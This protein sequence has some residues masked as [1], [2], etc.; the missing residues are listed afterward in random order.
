MQARTPRLVQQHVSARDDTAPRQTD[1]ELAGSLAL[2]ELDAAAELYDRYAGSVQGMVR[3]LLGPDLELDDVVQDV[4]LTALS[5][6]HKLRDPAFL[7]SWLLGIAVGKARGYLRAR[8]RR[9][10]LSFLPT[11]QLPDAPGPEADSH[12]D[13]GKEIAAVLDGLRPE[14]RIALLL[15]RVEGLSLEQGARAC[16]MS[17]STFKRRLTRGQQRFAS[18][19]RRRPALSLWL[20]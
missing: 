13:I 17:L 9:R 4:F 2:G 14:E 5:N 16:E 7:R 18:G 1:A 8:W 12:V 11:D 20:A 3:R 19:A 10:W 6:I 15:C